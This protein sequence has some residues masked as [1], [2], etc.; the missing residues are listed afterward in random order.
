MKRCSICKLDKD[1]SEFNKNKAKKDGLNTLCRECSNKRSKR[2]YAENQEHHCKVVRKRNL[3]RQK[4]AQ[5]YVL[6]VLTGAKC[7]DCPVTDVRVL[8]FDHVKSKGKK[9]KHVSKMINEGYGI[10]M[11]QKEIAKCEIVCANCH[12]IRT[13]ERTPSYRN[14]K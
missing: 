10:E 5:D 9:L 1:E 7:T 13:F 3:K 6:S 2:Y 8:E 12:R 14:K 4:E 11:L